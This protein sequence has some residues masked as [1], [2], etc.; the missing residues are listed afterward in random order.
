MWDAVEGGYAFNQPWQGEARSW[1]GQRETQPSESVP[2]CSGAAF[3]EVKAQG[4]APK[5]CCLQGLLRWMTEKP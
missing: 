5:P 1:A 4:S 2:V 3:L